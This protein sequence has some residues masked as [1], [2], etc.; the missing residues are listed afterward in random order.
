MRLSLA[1]TGPHQDLTP[2]NQEAAKRAVSGQAGQ[3]VWLSL[4]VP[5]LGD[6]Y[7]PPE[8]ASVPIA[9]LWH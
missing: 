8:K 9:I 7:T 1:D 5:N 6:A 4:M 2:K 3:L